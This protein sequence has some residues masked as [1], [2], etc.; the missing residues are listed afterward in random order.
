MKNIHKGLLAL[1]LAGMLAAP[2]SLAQ[3]QDAKASVDQRV[4][5]M[6]Q[7]GAAMGALSRVGRGEAPNDQAARETATRLQATTKTVFTLFPANS[8]TPDSRALPA[9]WTNRADFDAKAKALQDASDKIV[10]ALAANNQ[11]AIT[12]AVGEAGGTC[13]ACHQPY[14]RAQ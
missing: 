10:A 2:I 14:R 12:A 1:S 6:K 7:I 3:A 11:A 5:Q 9:I 13:A 4:A 8:V